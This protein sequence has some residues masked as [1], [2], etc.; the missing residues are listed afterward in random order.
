MASATRTDP[1]ADTVRPWAAGSW[2]T[3]AL[4]YLLGRVGYVLAAYRQPDEGWNSSY[5]ISTGW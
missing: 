4:G 2:L 5:T 1:A 3:L